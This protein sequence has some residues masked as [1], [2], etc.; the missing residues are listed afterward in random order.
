VKAFE[1]GETETKLVHARV[2]VAR[3]EPALRLAVRIRRAASAGPQK[4]IDPR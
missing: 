4:H 1:A 3:L 2:Q